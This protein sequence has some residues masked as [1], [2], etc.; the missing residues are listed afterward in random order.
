MFAI[1]AQV[2]ADLDFANLIRTPASLQR[3]LEHCDGHP[4][5][6]TALVNWLETAEPSSPSDRQAVRQASLRLLEDTGDGQLVLGLGDGL[7]RH[8][9]GDMKRDQ[10]L[11]PE[12][13][14][15]ALYADIGQAVKSQKSKAKAITVPAYELGED[16]S[17]TDQRQAGFLEAFLN[18]ADPHVV[19]M[20]RPRLGDS[21]H[22]RREQSDRGLASRR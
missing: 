22:N 1:S 11:V 8:A 10:T 17:V 13:L 4:E 3:T 5:F 12:K 14:A 18:L 6:E 21:A 20:V 19:H 2:Q 7:L 9:L 16:G 15:H